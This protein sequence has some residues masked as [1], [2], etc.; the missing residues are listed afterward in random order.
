MSEPALTPDQAPARGRLVLGVAWLG[1]SLAGL[2][3][4]WAFNLAFMAD[5]QGLGYLEG[6]FANPASSSA[7]VDI[8]V[9]ALAACL[10]MLVEGVRLGWA[11]WVWILVPLSFAIAIAFTFPLFLGIRELALRRRERPADGR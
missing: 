5:P 7:A 10:F 1:L 11:R 8:I 3:G 9:V 2:V 4:T 6:W